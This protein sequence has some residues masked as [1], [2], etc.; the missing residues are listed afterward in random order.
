MSDATSI[1]RLR[2]ERCWWRRRPLTA[3]QAKEL[4]DIIAALELQIA[5]VDS[6]DE[7]T[8][9][10]TL[11]D[12]MPL[13]W[14]PGKLTGFPEHPFAGRDYYL[15]ELA[16]ARRLRAIGMSVDTYQRRLHAGIRRDGAWYRLKGWGRDWRFPLLIV[17]LAVVLGV[18]GA[19]VYD[20]I[21][22][23]TH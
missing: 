12:G 8:F 20:S 9:R 3:E 21:R 17:V 2:A 4:D 23:T 14:F 7:E 5:R 22:G 19:A 13:P 15:R 6:G 11:P 16:T 10:R 18:L 1:T